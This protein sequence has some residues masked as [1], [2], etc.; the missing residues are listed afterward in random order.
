MKS[1]IFISMYV[2]LTAVVLLTVTLT[3]CESLNKDASNMSFWYPSLETPGYL[4]PD[5]EYWSYEGSDP[6][7][8]NTVGPRGM[9][10]RPTGFDMPRSHTTQIMQN[11]AANI[12][13][14][15]K[16]TPVTP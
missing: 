4:N 1:S 2:F 15:Q 9:Q 8:D 7:L 13:Y 12:K 3:G 14:E 5:H 11:R 16:S 10:A 6:Y